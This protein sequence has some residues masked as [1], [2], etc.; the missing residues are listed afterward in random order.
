MSTYSFL[1]TVAA[2]T[3]PGGVINLGAGAA[4]AEEGISITANNPIN[5]MAV[6]ADGAVMHSLHADKSGTVHIRLQ[7]T[8][9]VNQ[10]LSAMYALQTAVSSSHG[11]NTISIANSLTSDVITCRVVAFQKAPDLT[12][13]KDGGMNEWVFD[14][15]I[16]DRTLGSTN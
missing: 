16:I 12:Y 3:G 15:G 9:P 14:A 13:A 1:D 5:N 8:S 10:Q 6:G 4:S 11:K 2:L 7:K